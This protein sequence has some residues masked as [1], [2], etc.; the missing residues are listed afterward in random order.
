MKV[1]SLIFCLFGLNFVYSDNFKYFQSQQDQTTSE[2]S[3][4]K[5]LNFFGV[6]N[7]KLEV[8]IVNNFLHR[9]AGFPSFKL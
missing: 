7:K 2:N 3:S 5:L 1:I 6:N 4:D 9:I 8:T